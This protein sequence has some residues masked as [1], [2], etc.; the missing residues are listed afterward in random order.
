MSFAERSTVDRARFFALAS[1][2][3]TLVLSCAPTPLDRSPTAPLATGEDVPGAAGAR[4]NST[5]Q[6]LTMV[7]ITR[8]ELRSLLSKTQNTG[9]IADGP[10]AR[11]LFNA[12]LFILDGRDVPLSYLVEDPPRVGTDSWTVFPDGRMDTIYRLRPNLVWHGGAPL[13]AE[14]FVFGWRV[15]SDRTLS[16]LF[17]PSPQDLMEE[18]LAVGPRTVLIKWSRPFPDADSL[19][20]TRFQPL[21]RHVLAAAYEQGS[22]DAFGALPFWTREFVGAGPFKVERW[23][24]GVAIEGSAFDGHAL[25]RPKVDRVRVLFISDPNTVVANLL[26]G[27]AHATL[28]NPIRF[29]QGE[30][31]RN[32]WAL[33][34]AGE[35]LLSPTQTRYVQVQFRP[36][37]VNPRAIHDRR[38]REALIHSMDR[39]ELTDALLG[40]QGIV[41]DVLVSPQR[42]NYADI[43][44]AVKKYA[45]DP[46]RAEQLMGEAGFTKGSDGFYAGA[47]GERFSPEMRALGGAAEEQE[48]TALT[49]LLRR[50]GV[51]VQ[52]FVVPAAQATDGQFV[53]TFPAFSTSQTGTSGDTPL[54]KLWTPRIP[55]PQNRWNGTA[56]GGWSNPE[57]DRGYDAYNTTLDRAARNGVVAEMMKLVSEELPVFPLYYNFQV[58]AHVSALTGPAV[59]GDVSNVHE[60]RFR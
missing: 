41:A 21:P 44:R 60:W 34:R 47:P 48:L 40:G 20:L 4:G 39:K 57:Y 50:S 29:Q 7:V 49:D 22:A 5:P 53:A 42:E 8:I 19:I 11:R 58:D 59:A 45:Y 23:E 37:Y 3:V 18:V 36:E 55:S 15:F 35:V 33:S 52:P 2:A 13:T 16:G 46:R 25:G 54:V 12:A 51:N 30:V 31:L 26:S 1:V 6:G 24:A 17:S 27:A 43:D 28:D 56:L 14:D 9:V 32:A 10:S 38:V